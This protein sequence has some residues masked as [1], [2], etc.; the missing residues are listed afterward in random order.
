MADDDDYD[1][2]KNSLG[3]V[4]IIIVLAATLPNGSA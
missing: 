2:D 1:S 3:Q 4:E